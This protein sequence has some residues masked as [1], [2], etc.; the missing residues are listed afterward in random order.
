MRE[1][2]LGENFDGRGDILCIYSPTLFFRG[3]EKFEID[4]VGLD[5]Y[6]QLYLRERGRLQDYL[7]PAAFLLLSPHHTIGR[8][9]YCI[10]ITITHHTHSSCT[11]H[12][13]R[14]G[15]AFLL[16][17]HYISINHLNHL[18]CIT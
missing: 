14:E 10:I 2:V 6:I 7:N 13:G 12:G 8:E 9:C 15:K 18:L 16:F 1:S 4:R 11:H 5:H 17:L 3:N